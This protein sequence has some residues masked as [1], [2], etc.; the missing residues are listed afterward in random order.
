MFWRGRCS[1]AL[2]HPI[3]F[4]NLEFHSHLHGVAHA[5]AARALLCMHARHLASQ[6]SHTV[7]PTA[8]QRE[9]CAAPL[10]QTTLWGLLAPAPRTQTATLA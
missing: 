8:G 3:L 2:G 9:I 4:S 1:D 6:F 5:P 10:P 7:R